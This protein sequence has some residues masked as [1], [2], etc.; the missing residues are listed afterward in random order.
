M[1]IILKSAVWRYNSF[2][3]IV[4]AFAYLYSVAANSCGLLICN[5][6]TSQSIKC[7]DTFMYQNIGSPCRITDMI[8]LGTP[9]SRTHKQ[10]ITY[11]VFISQRKMMPRHQFLVTP[12]YT[13]ICDNFKSQSATSLTPT[14]WVFPAPC[15][16]QSNN[17]SLSTEFCLLLTRFLE[18][19]PGGQQSQYFSNANTTLELLQV[20]LSKRKCSLLSCVVS[21]KSFILSLAV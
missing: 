14:T 20:E 15:W 13:A 5:N 9:I 19:F 17:T 8:S 12:P 3:N 21:I 7:A 6:M 4:F 18:N 2:T 11:I 1:S 16:L 10:E